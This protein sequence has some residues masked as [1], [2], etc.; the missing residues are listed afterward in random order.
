MQEKGLCKKQEAVSAV[1][2]VGVRLMVHVTVKQRNQLQ[3]AVS[4]KQ[5]IE[6]YDGTAGSIM[7][8]GSVPAMATLELGR[9]VQANARSV[10]SFHGALRSAAWRSAAP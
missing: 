5:V 9:R 7:C 6:A 10:H 3:H 2:S 1:Q 4:N 8:K